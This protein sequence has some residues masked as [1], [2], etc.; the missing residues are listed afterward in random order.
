[1]PMTVRIEDIVEAMEMEGEETSVLLDFDTGKIEFVSYYLKSQAERTEDGE[2]PDLPEWE[3]PEW[4]IAKRLVSAPDSFLRLP[5][6]YEI[7][8]WSIMEDFARHFP[9]DAISGQLMDAIHGRGAF[10]NFKGTIRRLRLEQAWDDFYD[11]ALRQIAIDW[12]VENGIA[13]T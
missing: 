1:M 11:S 9:S 6:Q 8:E 7:H 3:K 12:C 10:R 4:E 5:D 2:E 13:Y